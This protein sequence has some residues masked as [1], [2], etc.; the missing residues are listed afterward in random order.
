MRKLFLI[1]GAILLFLSAGFSVKA[2][3]AS[4]YLSPQTR[5]Y[6]TGQTFSVTVFIKSEGIAINAAQAKIS[7]P[8]DIL[9]VTDISKS[10]SIFTLWVQR[11][12]FGQ[13]LKERFFSR[14]DYQARVFREQR[15]K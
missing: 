6:K 12:Q 9:K 11:N 3:E 1:L 5:S 8:S 15:E 13:I 4:F 14:G 7:F 2:Q 10:G